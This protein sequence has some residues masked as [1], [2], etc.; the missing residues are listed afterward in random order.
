MSDL[1][2]IG[3]ALVDV[4]ARDEGFILS[5]RYGISLPVQH[6][7]IEKLKELISE[8][9]KYT[10]VSGGGT[11][12]VAKIA[13]FLGAKTYFKGSVGSDD[14]GQLF[15]K[16][17]ADA[18]VN[19]NL[20]KSPSPTGIC[21]YLDGGKG[22]TRIAA[23]PSASLEF[24][25]SDINEEEIKKAAL[26]LIDGFMLHRPGLV[27]HVIGLAAKN[28]IPAALDLSSPD[29]AADYAAVIMDYA[30]KDLILFMNEEEAGAL[31]ESLEAKDIGLNDALSFFKS[32][33]YEKQF[34]IIAVK[35]GARGAKI[36][37]GGKIYCAETEEIV[38][39]DSTGAGDAFCAAFL[40][41][42]LLKKPLAECAALGNRAAGI[43]LK[44][45]GTQVEKE[46]LQKLIN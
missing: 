20:K 16:N 36:I 32:I 6:I 9:P 23:S 27:H 40:C 29:I 13:G 3:N 4:F 44:K 18:G 8:L 2:C 30:K 14:F 39:V 21:L 25:E 17:L 42:W 43:V 5:S 46:K 19:L 41:A 7:E 11:A 35:L 31:F 24:S 22:K 38:P 28:R 10:A 12:N 26:V 33:S 1:F 34:P 45:T 15:E 37:A